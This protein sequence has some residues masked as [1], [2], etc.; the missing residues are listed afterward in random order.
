MLINNQIFRLSK[1]LAKPPVTSFQV[2]GS[3]KPQKDTHFVN[4][5]NVQRVIR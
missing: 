2:L 5:M 4:L 3:P 1:T